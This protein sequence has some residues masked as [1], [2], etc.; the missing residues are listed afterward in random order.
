MSFFRKN[1]DAD[2]PAV[3]STQTELASLK[4]TPY[5]IFLSGVAAKGVDAKAFYEL[6]KKFTTP[7]QLRAFMADQMRLLPRSIDANP[8]F[9]IVDKL[10]R[11]NHAQRVLMQRVATKGAMLVTPFNVFDVIRAH[12]HVKGAPWDGKFSVSVAGTKFPISLKSMAELTGNIFD[13]IKLAARVGNTGDVA[14]YPYDRFV[15]CATLFVAAHF[16]VTTAGDQVGVSEGP[17][18]GEPPMSYVMTQDDADNISGFLQYEF[19]GII[20][21]LQGL[22]TEQPLGWSKAG[23][24]APLRDIYAWLYQNREQLVILRRRHQLLESW[25]GSRDGDSL[26]RDSVHSAPDSRKH[27]ASFVARE[28][29]DMASYMAL[30]TTAK[31]E[32]TV[33]REFRLKNAILDDATKVRSSAIGLADI[34]HNWE[35]PITLND[36]LN[37]AYTTASGAIEVPDGAVIV[38]IAGTSAAAARMFHSVHPSVTIHNV[39]TGKSGDSVFGGRS[40]PVGDVEGVKLLI[41]DLKAND[42]LYVH[43]ADPELYNAFGLDRTASLAYI[44]LMEKLCERTAARFVAAANLAESKFYV[45]LASTMAKSGRLVTIHENWRTHNDAISI[46][47]HKIAEGG[48]TSGMNADRILPVVARSLGNLLVQNAARN[49]AITLGY[50]QQGEPTEV[51]PYYA[52]LLHEAFLEKNAFNAEDTASA[53]TDDL[54]AH[55]FEEARKDKGPS[56]APAANPKKAKTVR[57]PPDFVRA[58]TANNAAPMEQEPPQA[59]GAADA[60]QD[61]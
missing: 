47:A 53:E 45:K 10:K 57:T 29:K 55:A 32:L 24:T 21:E 49:A 5:E 18:I 43:T 48:V 8:R 39:Y 26:L 3:K 11:A 2:A 22:P 34:A 6:I 27:V 58:A 51:T 23:I 44:H 41:K 20:G 17:S 38:I 46:V 52:R 15:F 61:V 14:Y 35:A 40:I 4:G 19:D 54:F 12:P 13:V 60:M 50:D 1:V 30:F 7:D 56:N 28:V 36:N 37:A 31:N 42:C 9:N 59:E 16:T 33:S 25:L